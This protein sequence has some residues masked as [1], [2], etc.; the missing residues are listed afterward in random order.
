MIV[1]TIGLSKSLTWLKLFMN[2]SN[3]DN[4]Y[5]MQHD[6]NNHVERLNKGTSEW[7]LWVSPALLQM[8]AAYKGGGVNDN[9]GRIL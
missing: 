4:H 6:R 1:L 5:V 8:D 2:K 9:L 3:D 7:K